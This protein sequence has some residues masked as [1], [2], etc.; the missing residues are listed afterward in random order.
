MVKIR[1]PQQRLLSMLDR[2]IETHDRLVPA[3]VERIRSRHPEASPGQVIARLEKRYL[4]AVTASGA[5]VG[6]GAAAPAIGLPVALVLNTAEFVG[7]VEASTLFILSVAEV[8][9]VRISDVERRRTLLLAVLVGDSAAGLIEKVTGRH[10]KHWAKLLPTGVSASTVRRLNETFSR[11]FV[12]RSGSKHGAVLIGRLAPFGVG[13]AI[14]G[15]GN[16]LLGKNVVESSRKAFGPAP[17][18]FPPGTIQGVVVDGGADRP[19]GTPARRILPG[20]PRA[21]G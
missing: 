11:W 5:A 16:A 14:G 9:G 6:A 12:T 1:T 15:A 4:T 21:D 13:A 8:H 19:P 10:D 7:F 3:H 20:R 2:T 18:S 17:H